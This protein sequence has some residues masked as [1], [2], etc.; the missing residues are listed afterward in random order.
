LGLLLI[1]VAL[2]FMP[3]SWYDRMSTLG[4]YESDASAV[5]RL[6]AWEMAI[7]LAVDRPLVGGGFEVFRAATYA[8]YMP[9]DLR[10]TDAHSIYFEV[11]A[12]HGFAGLALF[13]ALIWA[14]FR[15]CGRIVKRVG[16][17]SELR[18][19]RMLA[20]SLQVSILGYAAAG[21]FLGLAYFDLFYLV[22][23]LVA[24]TKV[25]VERELSASSGGGLGG[26]AGALKRERQDG[27][28]TAGVGSR[29]ADW[30][31]KRLFNWVMVW[32]RRL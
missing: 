8:I 30:W 26:G 27:E 32:W 16:A 11:L 24:G 9:W 13:V 31:A 19:A 4:D 10:N 29:A 3:E 17:A 20:E 12:E 22:V 2:L 18:W 25:A 23:A 15:E 28:G 6:R 14:A 1:P 7:N 21:T 5:G